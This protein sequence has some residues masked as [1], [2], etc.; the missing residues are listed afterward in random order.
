MMLNEKIVD[1]DKDILALNMK[2]QMLIEQSESDNKK[3][4]SLPDKF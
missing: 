2:I 4:F 3:Y 1:K